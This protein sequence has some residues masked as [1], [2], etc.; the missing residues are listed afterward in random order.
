MK[1]AAMP[2]DTLRADVSPAPPPQPAASP[3]RR[4]APRL[5]SGALAGDLGAG[6]GFAETLCAAGLHLVVPPHSVL[7]VQGDEA[8]GIHVLHAGQVKLTMNSSRGRTLILKISEPG[9]ILGL[10][11]CVSLATYEVSAESLQ[12]CEISFVRR[13]DFLRLLAREPQVL[14]AVAAQLSREC[15]SAYGLIHSLAASN[16]ISERLARLLLDLAEGD[17]ATVDPST[18]LGAGSRR[19]TCQAP[20]T[21]AVGL[22]HEE[23]AQMIGTSRE[24]VTRLLKEFRTRRLAMLK[25]STLH[26]LDKLGLEQMVPADANRTSPAM[27]G[28]SRGLANFAAT[29]RVGR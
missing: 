16:C 15:H 20:S 26:I 17:G 7:F 2:F 12:R 8:A 3:S 27:V 25:G 1:E 23:I 18:A 28:L 4:A 13:D 5:R 22:T 9:E 29:A 21:V 14:Q 24:T 19:S 10:H 6:A 11:N